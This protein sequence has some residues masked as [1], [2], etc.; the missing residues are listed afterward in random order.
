MIAK[1]ITTVSLTAKIMIGMLIGA[2][3]GLLLNIAPNFSGVGIVV[4]TLNVGGTIFIDAIK[5]LVVPLVLISLVCG[6]CSLDDLKTIG[7][8]GVK[9][10]SWIVFTTI[11]GLTLAV[12]MA[13]VFHVGAGSHLQALNDFKNSQSVSL[14]HFFTD[15][16]PSNIIQ[17]LSGT[18]ILQVIVVAI[19][20]GLSINMA[21]E[22]GKRIAVFFN[23]LN[24]V[25]IKAVMIVMQFTPYGVFCL[26][27]NLFAK[28]GFEIIL[29]LLS[30]FLTVIFVLI[31][32]AL[33]T[34][35]VLLK[36]VAGLSPKSFFRKMYGVMMFAFSTASSNATLPLALETVEQKLG[37]SNSVA[38][39]VMSLGINMNK[40]GTAI[41]QGV[42]AV[43]IANAYQVNIGIGG[44]LVIILTA[45]LASIGSAGAP[46]AGVLTLAMVLNQVGLPLDGIALILGVDRVIDMFRTAINVSGN[47]VIACLVGKS[48]KKLDQK[49][50]DSE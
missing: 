26:I 4:N 14:Q 13:N 33:V 49:V 34:Y 45:T 19:L 41:M 16:V 28:V 25:I 42:A 47:A 40:N 38:S 37:V 30:Y 5:M 15:L 21:G 9:T 50:Y 24:K 36:G 22:A 44:D 43:F 10:F 1:K 11:I 23:D 31:I 12:V 27:A 39:F 48:E 46:A 8:I 18:N 3:F 29:Q 7:K 20:L 6:I 17:A 35:S 2:V 32:H